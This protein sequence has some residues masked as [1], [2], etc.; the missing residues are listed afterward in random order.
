[1]NNKE[2]AIEIINQLHVHNI[3]AYI[4][5]V[6]GTGSVYVHFNEKKLGKLRVGDHKE[7]KCLGYRWQIRTDLVAPRVADS[8]GHKQF[9]YP[10]DQIPQLVIHIKNYHNTIVRARSVV[11]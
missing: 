10:E 4:F 7:K 6:A 11:K 5:D 3:R 1:M 8:K 2:I 9:L